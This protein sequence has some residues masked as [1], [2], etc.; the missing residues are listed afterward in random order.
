MDVLHDGVGHLVGGERREEL[1]CEVTK[2]FVHRGGETFW[3]PTW[4][5][6]GLSPS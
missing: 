5:T 4:R 6:A 3:L 1:G 2:S